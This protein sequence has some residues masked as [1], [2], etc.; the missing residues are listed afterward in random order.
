M[1]EESMLVH[2]LRV[3]TNATAAMMK[4]SVSRISML[5]LLLQDGETAT[6]LAYLVT[7]EIV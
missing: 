4:E 7:R 2:H 1:M 5:L 3:H 6:Y